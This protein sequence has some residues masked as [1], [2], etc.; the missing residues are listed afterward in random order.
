MCV[1]AVCVYLDTLIH[2]SM[3]AVCLTIALYYVVL[4][5]LTIA[6]TIIDIRVKGLETGQISKPSVL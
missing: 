5:S 6:Y 4:T 2:Y 3:I 1:L